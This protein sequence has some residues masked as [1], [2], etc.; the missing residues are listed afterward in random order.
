MA[1]LLASTA[2]YIP[3]SSLLGV[4]RGQYVI[5]RAPQEPEPTTL[6]QFVYNPYI[7]VDEAAD[8]IQDMFLGD[9]AD[10]EEIVDDISAN[11]EK[12]K[13]KSKSQKA[14]ITDVTAGVLYNIEVFGEKASGAVEAAKAFEAENEIIDRARSTV[15][16]VNDFAEENELGLKARAVFELL[17]EAAKPAVAAAAEG[18]ATKSKKPVP[19]PEP[20]PEPAPTKKPSFKFGI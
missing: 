8:A 20:E 16:A 2:A 6:D 13:P 4:G 18:L 7:D 14:D 10:T 5:M 3:A 17:F 11:M 9:I 1:L 15:D 12:P 19:K